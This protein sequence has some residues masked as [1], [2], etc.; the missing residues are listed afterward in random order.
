MTANPPRSGPSGGAAASLR[1]G[2]RIIDTVL[3]REAS[4]RAGFTVGRLADELGIER[5]KAS[6]TIQELC[7]KG[8]LERRED[9]T[10]RVAEAFLAT[11]ASLNSGWLRR[12]RPVLRRLA[13][14]HGASARLLV[15]DGVLV[16][17]LRAES[18]A[19]LAEPW[20]TRASLVTP[21]WCTGAGRA[22]LLD[23]TPQAIADLLHDYELVGVGGPHA[24]RSP[25][26]L[27]AANARDRTGGIVA[28]HGEYEHGVTEY[29][30]PVRD[31]GDHIRAAV[32]VLGGQRDLLP[33]EAEIRADLAAA[34]TALAG[35]L[36]GG[37]RL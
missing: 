2:L 24:A 23:H 6:R 26:E 28:A 21:C 18:A 19:G 32:A 3:D 7:D 27:V 29:A 17:L 16:R 13:V 5:S 4:G 30:V 10:L 14:A 33:R 11:A 15:R 8:F 12:S 31:A 1:T 36:D 25:G 22:L 9:S 20:L 37:D 34:A 35:F